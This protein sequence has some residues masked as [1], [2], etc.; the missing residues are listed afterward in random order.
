MRLGRWVMLATI[1]CDLR[2]AGTSHRLAIS[3]ESDTAS[4][5]GDDH[6]VVLIPTAGPV[7]PLAEP[8]GTP[9]PST[10]VIYPSRA[11]SSSRPRPSCVRTRR[12]P[13]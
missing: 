8:I 12:A 2:Q 3:S 13:R 11:P 5:H 6:E 9:T 1:A 10:V 4:D 7:W